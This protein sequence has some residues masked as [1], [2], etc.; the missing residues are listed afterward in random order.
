[1]AGCTE[2]PSAP[3]GIGIAAFS[4]NT[5]LG[6]VFGFWM[7]ECECVCGPDWNRLATTSSQKLTVSGL[8]SP[9]M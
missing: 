7:A 9:V 1:M 6:W 4:K 2:V 8:P 3:L 5:H